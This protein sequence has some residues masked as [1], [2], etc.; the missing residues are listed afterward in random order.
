L[1]GWRWSL[2]IYK[3]RSHQILNTFGLCISCWDC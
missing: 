2:Q 3:N 1:K